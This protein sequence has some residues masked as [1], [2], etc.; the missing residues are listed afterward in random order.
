MITINDDGRLYGAD[1]FIEQTKYPKATFGQLQ[2][3][4]G[5]KYSEDLV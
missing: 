1:A 3:Y 2:R 5:E 4:L